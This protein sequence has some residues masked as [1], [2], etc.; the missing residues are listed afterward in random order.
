MNPKALKY[1]IKGFTLAILLTS[2]PAFGQ[3]T[4]TSSWTGTQTIPDNNPA[5]VAFQFNLSDPATV[6]ENVSITLNV[7]GGYNGDI[8]AYLSHDS[9]FSVLLNRVG[10]SGVNAPGYGDSGFAVTL[11]GNA[12]G[13]I[14]QY[15]NQSPA[16]NGGGQLT[17]IWAADGRN[18]DPASAGS[19]FDTAPRN[20]TLSNYNGLNPNG[21]WTLFLADLA[22]G[23]ISTLN[24]YSVSVTAVPEPAET[25]LVFAALI[26]LAAVVFKR[27]N[28]MKKQNLVL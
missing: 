8:Y 19:A 9:G 24:G 14:H 7:T 11:S 26:G 25:G 1:V 5:G 6:I 17:G 3:V 12:L 15:R 27:H 10:R 18:L 16:F 23:E 2:L 4:L 13:D 20:S 21:T 28:K 22:F